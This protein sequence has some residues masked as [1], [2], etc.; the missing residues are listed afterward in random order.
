MRPTPSE[1]DDVISVTGARLRE[2]AV[3]DV[4]IPVSFVDGVLHARP[5][6]RTL[7]FS[8]VERVEVLRGLKARCPARTRRRARFS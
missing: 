3:H 8:D 1:V 2:D 7:D 6:A 5:A 4:P